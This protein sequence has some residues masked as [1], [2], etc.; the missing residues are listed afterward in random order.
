[1]ST[2]AINSCTPAPP[3]NQKILR[4]VEKNVGFVPNLFRTLAS[5]TG[6]VEAFVALDGA[7]TQSSLTPAECQVVMLTASVENTGTYCV[8]GHTL[9]SRKLGMPDSLISALRC[10]KPV[11]DE[12]LAALQTFVQLLIRARGHVT[13][14]QTAAFIQAGFSR[15]Q[16]LEVVM[17][18]ALKTFSNYVDS[19]TGLSLDGQFAD[20]RWTGTADEQACPGH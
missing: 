7:I 6:V 1:M 15:E 14:E 10:G 12:R 17:G 4:E 18:I 19:A 11:N 8:A 2:S 13:P 3:A 9:F 5:Q 16:V 20:A